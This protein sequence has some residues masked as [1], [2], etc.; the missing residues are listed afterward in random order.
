MWMAPPSGLRRISAAIVVDRGLDDLVVAAVEA[1]GDGARAVTHAEHNLSE[2]DAGLS[3][4]AFAALTRMD[5]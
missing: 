1:G 5:G 3:P 2:D 4:G